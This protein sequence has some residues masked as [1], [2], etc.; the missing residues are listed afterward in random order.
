[1]EADLSTTTARQTNIATRCALCGVS[2]RVQWTKCLTEFA[3]NKPNL[4]HYWMATFAI[5]QQHRYKSAIWT[6]KQIALGKW[7]HSVGV[8]ADQRMMLI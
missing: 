2:H 8:T 5:D 6:E 1:M 4:A 3:V 7:A